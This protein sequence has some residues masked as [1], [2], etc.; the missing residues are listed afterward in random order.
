MYAGDIWSNKNFSVPDNAS[1]S[2]LYG[3]L[4][5]DAAI[6]AL[7]ETLEKAANGGRGVPLHYTYPQVK[8]ILR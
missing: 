5:V 8:G 6:E 4:V 2:D 1:K 7:H 3:S